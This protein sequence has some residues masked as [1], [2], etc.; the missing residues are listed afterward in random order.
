MAHNDELKELDDLKIQ[1]GY[2]NEKLEKHSI[3][4][5]KMLSEIIGAR[6]N[7]MERWY[8]NRFAIYLI[9]PILAVN[10]IKMD[11]HWGFTALFV[12]ICIAQFLLD[13]KCY[14]TLNPKELAALPM[15]KAS[16]SVAQHRYWRAIADKAMI[17]P[18]IV[19][20]GW[21]VMI[22]YLSNRPPR[23]STIQRRL[24][25]LLLTAFFSIIIESM[26]CKTNLDLYVYPISV[27]SIVC[28]MT[29]SYVLPPPPKKKLK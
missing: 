19:L 16:E 24:P 8:R 28:C 26:K 11:F 29:Y 5:E 27:E 10:F 9:S 13:H 4:K 23:Y 12:A 6:L 17:L 18:L 21:A 1:F 3:V 20:A 14:Q 2:L 25:G 7:R 15:T 22:T